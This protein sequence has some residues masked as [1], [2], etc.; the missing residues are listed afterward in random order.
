MRVTFEEAKEIAKAYIEANQLRPEDQTDGNKLILS[1]GETIEKEYGWHFFS[2]PS[3]FIETED[4]RYAIAGNAPFL[5]EKENGRLV[6]FGT[7]YPIEY[8]IEQYE[9]NLLK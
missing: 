8:Y 7:A 9:K 5:I 6:E 1:E 4:I 3:K 2:A